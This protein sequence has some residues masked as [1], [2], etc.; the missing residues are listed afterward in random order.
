MNTSMS[1]EEKKRE[2]SKAKQQ[3]TTASR[4]LTSAVSREESF[5][6]L[7]A[8]MIE[9]DNNYDTFCEINEEYETIVLDNEKEKHRVVNGEDI[10][11]YRANV[12]K[13][14]EE[15]RNIFVQAKTNFHQVTFINCSSSIWIAVYDHLTLLAD[16]GSLS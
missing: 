5:E 15:A 2:R 6:T 3:V 7:K 12:M 8:L 10:P 14:Y 16:H 13:S 4:K 9:L 1:V 11:T